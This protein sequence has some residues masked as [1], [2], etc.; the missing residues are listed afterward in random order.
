MNVRRS[1]ALALLAVALAGP[2]PLVA[3]TPAPRTIEGWLRELPSGPE[4]EA[5]LRTQTTLPDVDAMPGTAWL[6]DPLRRTDGAPVRTAA[7]WSA[8][9]EELLKLFQ[10]YVTG[11]MPPAPGNVRVASREV[12]RDGGVT[13]EKLVLEFGPGHRARL[14]VELLIPEGPGPFPVFLSQENHRAWAVVA[15]SRG[16]LG[17]VY[18]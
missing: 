13:Q 12:K 8:R 7:G 5:W 6:P 17:C 10:H 2:L 4:W 3:S 1:T 11:T 18:A 15:V 14:R 9:R 16:Y